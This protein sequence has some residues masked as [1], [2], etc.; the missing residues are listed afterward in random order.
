M[1]SELELLVVFT[2]GAHN[3]AEV[4]RCAVCIEVVNDGR[5]VTVAAGRL[6]STKRYGRLDRGPCVAPFLG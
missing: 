3:A 2:T 5:S 4:E 1:N 6:R